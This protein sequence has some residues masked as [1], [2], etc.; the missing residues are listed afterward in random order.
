MPTI[1]TVAAP[2]KLNLALSVGAPGPDRMHPISSWM[3]T[4][5]FADDLRLERLPEGS[6]SM[7]A[8]VWHADAPRRSEIDWSITKDL[9]YRAHQALERELEMRLPVR[10]LITKRIPVGGGLGGGSSNAAAMLRALDALFELGLPTARLASVAAGLGSD[11]PFL[12]HGG[13]AIVGG[14]GDRIEP[15]AHTPRAHVALVFPEVP[16]PTAQVYRRFDELGGGAAR[17]DEPRVRAMAGSVGQSLVPHDAP[18]NDLAAP[19]LDVAPS[20]RAH[21]DSIGRIAERGVHVSGSGSTLF[22]VCDDPMHAEALARAIAERTGLPASAAQ[23]AV[24]A[25]PMIAAR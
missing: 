1:A 18:F 6:M 14:L 2:S 17:A 4:L 5:D 13:S 23:A 24:P 11:I 15:L 3:V 19:A 16:C 7:F 9:A 20:L 22:V 25:A 21:I 8:T 12:V 10:S